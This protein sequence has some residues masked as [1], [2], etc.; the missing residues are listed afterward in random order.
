AWS[1]VRYEE[2]LPQD[3]W[4][5]DERL[6]FR[7]YGGIVGGHRLCPD[8]RSGRCGH[9][10]RQHLSYPRE[11]GGEDVFRTWSTEEVERQEG[12][13]RPGGADCGRRM[14]CAGRRP[15]DYSSPESR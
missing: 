13:R 11:G 7:P 5:S 1:R 2:A 8:L 10:D 3:L 12:T 15:R 14:R 6:R 4:L 9:G